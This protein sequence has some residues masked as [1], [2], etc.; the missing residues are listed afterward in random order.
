MPS[1]SPYNDG[2]N[3][4]R[5][6]PMSKKLPDF[7]SINNEDFEQSAERSVKFAKEPEYKRLSISESKTQ[8]Q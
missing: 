1:L 8:N 5:Q 4:L 3:P 2:Q 7:K 6:T